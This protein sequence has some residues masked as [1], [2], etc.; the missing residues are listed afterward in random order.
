MN[1]LSFHSGLAGSILE[2]IGQKQSIGY[3]Y[4]QSSIILA[5][6]DAMAAREFP[7]EDTITKAMCDSWI[8][9]HSHLHQNTLM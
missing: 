4:R 6:F 7:K 5:R 9:G 1:D 2:F 8:E 3:P